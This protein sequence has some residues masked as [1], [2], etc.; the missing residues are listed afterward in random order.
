ME[1]NYKIIIKLEM[2]R[3][4]YNP[5]KNIIGG[6]TINTNWVIIRNTVHDLL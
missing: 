4:F 6:D 3:K 5:L 2:I 1:M